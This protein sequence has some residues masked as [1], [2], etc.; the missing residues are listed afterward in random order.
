M[1]LKLYLTDSYLFEAMA[2]VLEVTRNGAGYDVVLDRTVLFPASGGQPSDRGWLNEEPVLEIRLEGPRVVHHAA[3]PPRDDVVLCRVDP[4]PRLDHMQQ[5]TGQHL[6][7]RMFLDRLGAPT[8]AFHLGSATCTIDVAPPEKGAGG[9]PPRPLDEAA[10]AEIEQ[11]ANEQVQV[12]HAIRAAS[13]SAMEI[14]AAPPDLHALSAGEIRIIDIHGVD[15]SFCCGTHLR[16]TAEVGPIKILGTE[17]KGQ[18][19]KVE[20]LCGQRS[21]DHH[22]RLHR[23]TTQLIRTSSARIEELPAYL[24]GLLADREAKTRQIRGLQ[25][26]LAR[27]RAELLAA[28]AEPMGTVRLARLL[29][30]GGTAEEIR[31]M[32]EQL[33]AQHRCCFVGGHKPDTGDKGV[34]VIASPPGCGLHAG[35]L[36]GEILAHVGGRGG[37]RP[38]LAQGGAPADRIAEAVELAVAEAAS[39]LRQSDAT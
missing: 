4:E 27:A 33:S 19:V 31:L 1:T 28:R 8:V 14:A 7:S 24:D 12:G 13:P 29:Q 30:K 16:S 32:A 17:R 22:V 2:R 39:R 37:G 15:R 9:R 36:L 6:L 11:V 20:F 5:H 23:T 18:V 26:E 35:K 25:G 34:L 21:R 38:E 10:L 3:R